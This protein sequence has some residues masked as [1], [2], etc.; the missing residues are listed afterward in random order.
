MDLTGIT[1][2][3][4]NFQAS[5]SEH[6][7]LV[8]DR[9]LWRMEGEFQSCFENCDPDLLATE[10]RSFAEGPHWS[11]WASLI[12][13][14][15]Y[16]PFT[17]GV[18]AL[19]TLTRIRRTAAKVIFRGTEDGRAALP[20]LVNRAELMVEDIGGTGNRTPPEQI[21]RRYNKEAEQKW[22]V[23]A[24]AREASFST[25]HELS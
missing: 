23:G 15:R 11:M 12:A 16:D 25:S 17:R 10:G 13:V 2:A 7:S 20:K 5:D 18:A 4:E 9:V 3:P 14:S 21:G 19:V 22:T 24:Y 6:L 1:Q 8:G